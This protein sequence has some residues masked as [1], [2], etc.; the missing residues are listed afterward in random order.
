MGVGLSQ[1]DAAETNQACLLLAAETD[2][3]VLEAFRSKLRG[4]RSLPN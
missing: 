2:R 4:M 3:R 1:G